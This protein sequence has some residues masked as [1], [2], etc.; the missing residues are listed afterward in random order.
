MD[1]RVKGIIVIVVLFAAVAVILL[2][3]GPDANRTR[4]PM[5]NES[6]PASTG[7]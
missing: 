6:K 3:I 4:G 1:N 7:A 5:I 2:A